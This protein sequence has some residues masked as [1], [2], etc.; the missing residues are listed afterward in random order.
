MRNTCLPT[1]MIKN[2]AELHTQLQQLAP[3]INSFKSEAVQL[4]IV[5]LVFSGAAL[6]KEEEVNANDLSGGKGGKRRK[7]KKPASQGA[8]PD[9]EVG[10]TKIKSPRKTTSGRP[11]PGAIVATLQ[12]EGFFSK[13]RGPAEIIDHCR[14]NK[15]LTYDNTEISVALGRAVKAGKLKREKNAD[16]QFRYSAS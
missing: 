1:A 5:E 4:R 14:T 11:G 7:R 9:V 8:D 16:G 13:A 12:K 3:T 15:V 6:P 2:F 10:G